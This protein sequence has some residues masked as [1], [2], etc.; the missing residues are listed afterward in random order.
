MEAQVLGCRFRSDEVSTRSQIA[1]N[2]AHNCTK[3]SAEQVAIHGISTSLIN[4]IS[5]ARA[6]QSV[7]VACSDET[8]PDWTSGGPPIWSSQ[9]VEERTVLHAP[10]RLAGQGD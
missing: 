8:H 6:R 9:R 1:H 5:D 3:A 2:F 10:D 4:G 7:P